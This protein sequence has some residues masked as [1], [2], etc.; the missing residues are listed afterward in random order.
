MNV[1]AEIEIRVTPVILSHV[2][3]AARAAQAALDEIP[4][5]F[6]ADPVQLYLR[7]HL[8]EILVATAN[9]HRRAKELEGRFVVAQHFARQ[10]M[11][12][13]FDASRG[14]LS[15]AQETR[16]ALCTLLSVL[17]DDEALEK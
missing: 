1:P 2:E 11:Q 13:T 6:A 17:L 5:P 16:D 3:A 8:A 4:P 12:D 15:D 14:S 10:V 9:A 7:D